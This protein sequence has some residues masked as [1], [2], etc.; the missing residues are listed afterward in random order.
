M[1]EVAGLNAP[2]FFLGEW[3]RTLDE[4]YRLSLPPEWAEALSRPSA[5]PTSDATASADVPEGRCM[6]AKERPGCVSLWN[7]GIWEAWLKSG[8]EVIASKVRSGR[9]ER[10]MDH[11]QM[12]GRLLSTRHREAPL[13]GRGRLALPETFRSFLG[14]EPGGEI[15][16]VGA[17]VCVE[18]WN[19]TAWHDHIGEHMPS[20]RQLFEQL[21][22]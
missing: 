20:F 6:L 11:V 1:S 15:L 12:L 16:V 21:A 2:E 22:E 10:R 4:R 3:S 13:A 9:L 14:V 17:G 5:A 18:V 7:R 19:P 8:V